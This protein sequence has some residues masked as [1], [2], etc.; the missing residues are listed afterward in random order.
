MG[1]YDSSPICD[2]RRSVKT[3]RGEGREGV[4]RQ[5]IRARCFEIK[6][7]EPSALLKGKITSLNALANPAEEVA[8]NFPPFKSR[9][10]QSENMTP[11]LK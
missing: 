2:Y 11:Y 10:G 3:I 4:S 6:H 9:G 7:L 8:F 1:N 5:I